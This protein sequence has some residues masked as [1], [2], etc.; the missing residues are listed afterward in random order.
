MASR[1]PATPKPDLG[2]LLLQ[3]IITNDQLPLNHVQAPNRSDDVHIDV[4]KQAL[5]LIQRK[6]KDT[7]V[8]HRKVMIDLLFI[9]NIW[10]FVNQKLELELELNAKPLEYQQTLSKMFQISSDLKN[11]T[12]IVDQNS[13]QIHDQEV[14][15]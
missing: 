10:L 11:V 13:I 1:R 8:Q 7:E 3:Y 12:E 6:L 5:K 15:F 2:S 9:F 4:C 14:F